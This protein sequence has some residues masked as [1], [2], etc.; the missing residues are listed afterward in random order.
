MTLLTQLARLAP[1]DFPVDGKRRQRA[2][3]LFDPIGRFLPA[4]NIRTKLGP[5]SIDWS[6]PVERALSYFYHNTLRYYS[7]SQLGQY[8]ARMPRRHDTFVDVGAN[9]GFYSLIARLHGLNVVAVEPEPAHAAFLK[10]NEHIFG[11]VCAVAMSDQ[12]G[13]LPLYYD[14]RYPGATS[15]VPAAGFEKGDDTV[16]V[17]TFSDVAATGGFGKCD[18]IRLIKIDVE[19]HE[20]QTVAGLQAFLESGFR[21]DIWCEVRGRG[22]QRA[23]NTYLDVAKF[24][25][26]YGYTA[27]T[28][29]GEPVVPRSGDALG[30]TNVFDLLFTSHSTGLNR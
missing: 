3:A 9:L 2:F 13:S 16:A 30:N 26:R 4:R 5:I 10:R 6:N 8:I 7:K 11:R 14:R 23:A 21:P 20:V 28:A 18:H 25:E 27:N 22:S 29:E 24:L 17:T 1:I 12:P 19:G 15:L